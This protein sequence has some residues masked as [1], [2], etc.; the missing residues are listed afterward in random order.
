MKKLTGQLLLKKVQDTID[1]DNFT[2]TA[3]LASSCG[4]ITKDEEGKI[5]PDVMAYAKA[6]H[7]A[8]FGPPKIQKEID[9][10]SKIKNDINEFPNPLNRKTRS[11]NT[12]PKILKNI[13]PKHPEIN[14][15]F[16]SP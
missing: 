13:K 7:Y 12:L 6:L 5:K 9:N 3:E 2:N 8:K 1:S 15:K 16:T 11:I 14:P 4:Y 10:S